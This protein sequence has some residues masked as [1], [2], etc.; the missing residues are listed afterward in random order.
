MYETFFTVVF[1]SSASDLPSPYFDAPAPVSPHSPPH[2]LQKLHKN[3]RHNYKWSSTKCLTLLQTY[4]KYKKQ[5]SS[6]NTDEQDVWRKI[7]QEVRLRC[8]IDCDAAQCCYKIEG[9][10]SNYERIKDKNVINQ[11]ARMFLNEARKAFEVVGNSGKH[12]TLKNFI[13]SCH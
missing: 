11:H 10:R 4:I 3:S 8:S 1:P 6:P 9:L 13:Q 2:K 7:A 12:K 5:L